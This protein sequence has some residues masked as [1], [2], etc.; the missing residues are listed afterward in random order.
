MDKTLQDLAWSLLPKEFKEEVKKYYQGVCRYDNLYSA[1]GA[2]E[3]LE[4]LFGKHNLTS[5]AEGEEMLTV[6]RKAVIRNYKE[7]VAWKNHI[8]ASK[9]D[10]DVNTG[11][12]NALRFLFGLKCLPD[13]AIEQLE[14]KVNSDYASVPEKIF[15]SKWD[16]TEP[17]PAGPKFKVGDILSDYYCSDTPVITEVSNTPW[18]YVYCLDNQTD[19]IYEKVI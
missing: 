13:E 15:A 10:R 5:D 9:Y 17:K 7:K 12:C 11:W 16:K 18:G 4:L 1:L 8:Q 14:P 19:R 3:I 2:T 6:S